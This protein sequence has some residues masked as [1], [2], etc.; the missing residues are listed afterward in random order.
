M[1]GNKPSSSYK[2]KRKAFYGV[3]PQ[4][5]DREVNTQS[6]EQSNMATTVVPNE[7]YSKASEFQI[8]VSKR[9]EMTQ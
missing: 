1:L 7:T 6:T 2:K 8:S 3:R 4:E 9:N 5:M